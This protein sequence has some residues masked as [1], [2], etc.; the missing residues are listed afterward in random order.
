MCDLVIEEAQILSE[1]SQMLA[2]ILNVGFGMDI[3]SSARRPYPRDTR[4]AVND[5]WDIPPPEGQESPS[6]WNFLIFYRGTRRTWERAW[7]CGHALPESK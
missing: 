3:Q 1:G 7:L 5:S 2:G 6:T 4:A